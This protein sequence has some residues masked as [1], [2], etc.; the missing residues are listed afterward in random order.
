MP[1]T[2]PQPGSDSEAVSRASSA[3][4]SG[5]LVMDCSISLHLMRPTGTGSCKPQRPCSRPWQAVERVTGYG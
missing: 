5:C 2:R 3:D 4:A 1:A